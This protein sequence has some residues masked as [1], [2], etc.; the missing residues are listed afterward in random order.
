MPEPAH[1]FL[2]RHGR[3]AL[4]AAGA[5]RGHL[6]PPL[7][8]S[9]LA[10][11]ARLADALAASGP[12]RIVTSPLLRAR[13]TAEPLAQR[14]HLPVDTDPRLI[15]RDYGTW[16]GHRPEELTKRFGSVDAAP[17]VERRTAVLRRA[18][19]VLD[20]QVEQ[21]TAGPVVLVAHDVVNRLLLHH[22][23]P[24]LGAVDAIPQRTGCWNVLTRADET[25]RVL[26][27]DQR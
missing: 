12:A 27:V 3:T 21:L 24:A 8:E 4:N 22:L 19:A 26:H 2:L 11:A 7:D 17:G 5:L 16:A 6:D 10:E 9:G 23:D 14:C 25:W 15:D 13:Q 1:V 20:E 18:Q